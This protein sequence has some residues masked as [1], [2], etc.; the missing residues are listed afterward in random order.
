VAQ[1]E[2]NCGALQFGPLAKEQ[3]DEIEGILGRVA[4]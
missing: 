3:M 2:D 4:L 1:V